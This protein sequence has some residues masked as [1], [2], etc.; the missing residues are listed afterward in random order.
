VSASRQAR[1][2]VT[3]L[4]VLLAVS[5]CE[6]LP[7]SG[8]VTTEP[9]REQAEDEAPVD[10]TPDG[11]ERGAAPIEIVRG[12]LTAM[13]ATPLNTSTA[14]RFLTTQ[15]SSSW[16]PEMGT[17]VHDGQ[18]LTVE[19]KDV[20]LDLQDT[21]RLDE[22]GA[23]LGSAGDASYRI[24]M[25]RE[26]GEWRISTPPDRLI[27]PTTHFETR[28]QQYFL[29][30]FDK[31]AQVL[32][33]E[34]VYVPTGA[35]ATTFLVTGLLRG[36][37]RGLLG[38]ERTFVPARTRLDDISVPVTPEG[39]AEV[40]LS[41]E[42][43]DLEPDQLSKAFAQLAWTLKQVSGVRRLRVTV[44]GSPLEVPGQGPDADI[45]GWSEFDPSVSWASQSLFGIRGGRVVTQIGSEER[46]VSGV[47]GSLDL[48]PD[49]IAVD[50]PG[51]QIAATTDDG[52]VL[53]AARSRVA[54]TA[55]DA[56]DA[57]D[58]YTAEGR[59]L[60]PSWDLHSQLWVVDRTAAGA[61]VVVVRNSID[62]ELDV[63]GL[64]GE[65]V[66]SLVVSRD[67]SRLVAQVAGNRRDTLVIGRIERDQ[68]GKVR[69]VVDVSELDVSALRVRRIRDVAWRTPGSLAVLTAP[70]PSTSQVLVVKVDGSSTLEDSTTDAEVFR[71]EAARIITSST[72]GAP[73]YLRS[74][75][76]AMY[77]LASN[78]RWTGAGVRPGLRSPTFVG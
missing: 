26:G 62:R 58:V 7:A 73:L 45:E 31:A 3:L 47:L 60:K 27:V 71:G 37:G 54:G 20:R 6:S 16:V 77:A 14:R 53:L 72:L 48:G 39:T 67:G 19:G 51:E 40:P 78:A 66:R 25:V 57:L 9:V 50:L 65:D 64:T 74:R 75:D 42:V 5:G 1:A 32:V 63:D 17:V 23:W 34:P 68:S 21:V 36:P 4:A 46:R 22:R 76:G 61:Q 33:P 28:F 29:Y 52:R 38:V 30:F 55:P 12:F 13:Q 70:T 8:P 59:L 2:A 10:F 18:T 44:D 15:S 41:D 49:T 35:Q 11:P 69:R 43:L 56:A 24:D